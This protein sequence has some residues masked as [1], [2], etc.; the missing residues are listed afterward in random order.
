MSVKPILSTRN[1]KQ[2]DMLNGRNMK[3]PTTFGR[4]WQTMLRPFSRGF[5]ETM[6]G[7]AA[8]VRV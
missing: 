5:R 7:A 2:Q 3:H 4:F 8:S 1:N 6:L